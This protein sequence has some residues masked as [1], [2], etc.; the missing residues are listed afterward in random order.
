[1]GNFVTFKRILREELPKR[2]K[3]RKIYSRIETEKMRAERKRM[4]LSFEK[5]AACT[6]ISKDTLYRYEHGRTLAEEKN[7][8]ALNKFFGTE[9]R[10]GER[11]E[12]GKVETFDFVGFKA[13][14]IAAPFELAGKER[15]LLLMEKERDSRTIPKRAELLRKIDVLL[16]A[17]SFFLTKKRKESNIKG[18]AAISEEELKNIETASELVEKIKERS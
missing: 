13:V 18:V 14:T 16:N 4:N 11:V 9:I 5:L 10:V 2:R 8:L 12:G 3:Y 17:C 6:G 7:A 1:V 15:S